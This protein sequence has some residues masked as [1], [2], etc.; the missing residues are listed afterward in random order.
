MILQI[1]VQL[2]IRL[3]MILVIEI[4]N[5]DIKTVEYHMHTHRRKC[6]NKY[7]INNK[8]EL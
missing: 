2:G 1:I 8:F 4:I 6:I 3:A 5:C 7:L